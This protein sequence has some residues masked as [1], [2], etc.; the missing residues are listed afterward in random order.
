[1]S[2]TKTLPRVYIS[3]GKGSYACSIESSG[4]ESS[5]QLFPV[6]KR[7]SSSEKAIVLRFNCDE[8]RRDPRN[9]CVPALDSFEDP[10]DPRKEI[11]V[12]PM[13]RTFGSP[14]FDTVQEV[15][16]FTRQ[17]LEVLRC[18]TLR[19]YENQLKSLFRVCFSCTKRMWPIGW[20]YHTR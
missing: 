10:L 2:S 8:M 17:M 9:H 12:M 14:P 15:L 18:G 1:M 20:L 3:T 7:S 19:S 6:T 13:L 16:E 4:T 11:I 5:W